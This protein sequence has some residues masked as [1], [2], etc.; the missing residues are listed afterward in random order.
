M[1]GMDEESSP[2]S[3]RLEEVENNMLSLFIF[4]F[5]SPRL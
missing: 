3:A 4:A 5:L 1:I 2:A